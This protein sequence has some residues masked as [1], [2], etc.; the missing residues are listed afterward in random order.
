M[1][2]EKKHIIVTSIALLSFS[3]AALYW[4]YKRLT[5]SCINLNKLGIDDMP[6]ELPCYVQMVAVSYFQFIVFHF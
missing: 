5:D 3:A 4:Q 6:C 2:I 1:K